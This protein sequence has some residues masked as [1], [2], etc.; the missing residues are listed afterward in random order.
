M[1]PKI[2]AFELKMSYWQF[3]ILVALTGE[4]SLLYIKSAAYLM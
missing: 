2:G 4:I 3:G 1:V